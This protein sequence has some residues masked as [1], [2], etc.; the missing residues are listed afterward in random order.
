[1][2]H[3]RVSRS[4]QPGD[5][6][7]VARRGE[8]GRWL[9][10]LAAATGACALLMPP[11]RSA[12]SVPAR[13]RES[14]PSIAVAALRSLPP[15]ARSVRPVCTKRSVRGAVR[16]VSP[17]GTPV[18]LGEL[19]CAGR[20]AVVIRIDRVNGAEFTL[21]LR[22]NAASGRWRVVDRTVACARHRVPAKIRAMACESN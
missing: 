11:G 20:W 22:W 14:S 12:A 4:A 7:V 9:V 19:A 21:V 5:A 2:V 18:V 10:V 15:A 1:V 3:G 8:L 16:A 17:R 13:G 6:V